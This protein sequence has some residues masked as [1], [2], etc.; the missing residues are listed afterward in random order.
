MPTQ[1]PPVGRRAADEDRAGGEDREVERLL[2]EWVVHEALRRI[3]TEQ[4]A[5]LLRSYYGG[6]PYSDVAQ[7]LRIPESTARTR[8]FYGLRALRA[9][10]AEL[11]WEP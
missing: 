7:D 9:M 3:S 5:V 1:D 2:D 10:L 11:G 8:A 4:R 6:E